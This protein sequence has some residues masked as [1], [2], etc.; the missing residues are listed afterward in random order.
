MNTIKIFDNNDLDSY[1][2]LHA[3]A[4]KKADLYTK[5]SKK[6]LEIL[7]ERVKLYQRLIEYMTIE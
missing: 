5:Q 1:P 2:I 7:F 3:E 6:L 4:Y